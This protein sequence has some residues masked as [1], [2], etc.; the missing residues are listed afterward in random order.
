MNKENNPQ[1]EESE[2][3][4]QEDYYEIIPTE[5]AENTEEPYTEAPNTSGSLAP[6]VSG[7]LAYLF[8][9][10]SGIIFLLVEKENK[11]VRFHAWQSIILSIAFAIIWVL[12]GIADFILAYIPI[13]GWIIGLLISAGFGLI[14]F[15]VWI[16]MMVRAYQGHETSIPLIGN[17]ARNLT[18]K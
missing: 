12:V 2:Q 6:N 17:M 18:D 7:V 15:I 1:A 16:F 3:F 10:I 5:S 8:W 14:T 9:F 4:E 11:F 13:L